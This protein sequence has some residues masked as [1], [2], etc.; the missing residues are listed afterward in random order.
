MSRLGAYS[1]YSARN[2]CKDLCV[3]VVLVVAV[4]QERDPQR[5]VWE[6]REQSGDAGSTAGVG[7]KLMQDVSM[8]SASG[9][10]H[11]HGGRGASAGPIRS[12]M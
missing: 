3:G 12:R 6:Q 1:Q 2:S 10:V 7:D 5:V 8:R 9:R 4:A 11:A